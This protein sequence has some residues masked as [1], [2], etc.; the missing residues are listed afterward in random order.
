VRAA[1]ASPFSYKI[2]YL[3]LPRVIRVIAVAHF[4]REPGYWKDRLEP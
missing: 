3:E 1:D 2:L 4:G